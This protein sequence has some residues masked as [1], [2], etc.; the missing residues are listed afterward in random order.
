[1]TELRDVYGI[2]KV[3]PTGNGWYTP[4]LPLE[5]GKRGTNEPCFR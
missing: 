1:M 4:S 2:T 5:K 3:E